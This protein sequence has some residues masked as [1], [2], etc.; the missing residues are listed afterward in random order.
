MKA[1]VVETANDQILELV[2]EA[3]LSRL[4]SYHNQD[5]S[6]T[7]EF[8]QAVKSIKLVDEEGNILDY[9]LPSKEPY[10]NDKET[11]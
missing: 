9:P 3:L 4:R 1:V 8:R 11:S 7:A 6:S 10:L 5:H 2:V